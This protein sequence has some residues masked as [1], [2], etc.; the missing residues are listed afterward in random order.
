MG[1]LARLRRMG[2][3]LAVLALALGVAAAVAGPASAG[4]SPAM[5][6]RGNAEASPSAAEPVAAQP[7]AARLPVGAMAAGSSGSIVY[8]NGNN[9]WVMAPD[10]TGKRQITRDGTA[11]SPYLSPT[12]ADDGTIVAVRNSS[13]GDVGTIYVLNRAGYLMN[14][15]TPPQYDYHGVG[16]PCSTD[17]QVAP[18]GIQRATVSPDGSHVAYTAR[19]MFQD[20]GCSTVVNVFTSYVVGRTGSGAVHL[21][22]IQDI[23]SSEVGGWAGNG[24]IL[25]SNLAFGEVKLYTV[26]VPGNRAALWKSDPDEWDTAWEGPSRGGAVLATD[27]WSA[28][29]GSNVV[30][31]WNAPSLTGP[32]TVR[33][34]IAA[35]AGTSDPGVFG[36][37]LAWPV[38]VAPTGG[39]VTWWETNGDASTS[40][41]DE[42][43]YVTAM[44]SSGCPSTKTLIA[45]GGSFPF[46]GSATVNAPV[47]PDRVA[48]VV[49][50]TAKPAGYLR[51]TSGSI[52]YRISDATD[53]AVTTTCTLDARATTCAS[54]KSVSH[55]AQGRH[56]FV[57]NARD[58]AGNI[59]HATVNWTVDTGL[60][61][62]SVTAPAPVTTAT[63]LVYHWSGADAVSGVASYDVQ[64]ATASYTG[65]FS[66]W[67]VRSSGTGATSWAMIALRPGYTY[68]VRVRAHDRAGNVSAYSPPG[69][70]PAHSMT[71]LCTPPP[72]GPG[73]Q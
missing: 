8:V 58:H 56:S 65:N 4:V 33:C 39:G 61:R 55:L 66:G 46:W 22:D 59:G 30:R 5:A 41:A 2:S 21:A 35:T 27:G 18:T 40:T 17:Y 29:G 50:V 63:R 16:M 44:P 52:S 23:D 20:V 28:G 37:P 60:P 70:P 25:L 71:A 9:V 34:E 11:P 6:G 67:K 51:S 72:G 42:G 31:L 38:S 45:P 53:I 47:P 3:G 1:P 15:F 57:I 68:C 49:T 43:I 48:P 32:P 10:G 62:I 69:A 19:A 64:Y 36:T 14:R 12:E 13:A 54:P 73:P 26:S 24:T 7:R